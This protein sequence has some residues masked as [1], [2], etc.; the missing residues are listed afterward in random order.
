MKLRHTFVIAL[1][2]AGAVFGAEP[3]FEFRGVVV[4]GGTTKLSLI[5]KSHNATQW[6]EAGHSFAGFLVSY[7]A[8]TETATLSKD[9]KEIRLRL[10]T[11]KIPEATA[12]VPEAE[13][14]G[15]ATHVISAGETAAKIAAQYQLTVQ[16][17]VALNP[18]VQ[19]S[20][21]TVGQTVKVK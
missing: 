3:E 8:A 10:S 11:S 13:K 16:Q 2:T 4:S 6:V 12:K 20:R 14:A 7:D 1:V 15:P 9:G 19:W 21:L 17:L 5:D 18:G